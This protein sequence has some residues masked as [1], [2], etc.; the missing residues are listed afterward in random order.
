M[1]STD[2]TYLKTTAFLFSAAPKCTVTALAC[3]RDALLSGIHDLGEL[4][5]VH[6]LMNITSDFCEK[7]KDVLSK[8]STEGS[9]IP[10]SHNAPIAPATDGNVPPT[11]VAPSGHGTPTANA[12]VASVL[13][14]TNGHG[15]PTTTAGTA[16]ALDTPDVTHP[17]PG[18]QTSPIGSIRPPGMCEEIWR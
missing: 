10:D 8:L 12:S 15:T 11:S 1:L 17:T 13:D 4:G 2:A 16:S 3:A 14:V 5:K 6:G 18:T 9:Q 7:N